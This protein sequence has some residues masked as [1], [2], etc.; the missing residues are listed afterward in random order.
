MPHPPPGRRP[1]FA[2]S[3]PPQV[4]CGGCWA[5]ASTSALADR[6]NIVRGGAFPLA[7]LSVQNVV[8][9]SK[10]GNCIDGGEDKVRG[11]ACERM[12][13]LA[14]ACVCICA[15]AC[16]YACFCINRGPSHLLIS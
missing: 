13:L 5:F 11:S 12:R 6:A 16:A 1:L 7:V 9:C 15:H 4:Y 10:G 3:P 2:S 14:H 8:D